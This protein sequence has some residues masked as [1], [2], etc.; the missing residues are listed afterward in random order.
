MYKTVSKPSF[1]L[2]GLIVGLFGVDFG[3]NHCVSL[4][5]F[6][7]ID[8]L[9]KTRKINQLPTKCGFERNPYHYTLKKYP[10]VEKSPNR[11]WIKAALPMVVD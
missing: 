10:S 3:K 5:T 7:A 2:I 1:V 9:I 8:L 6:I 11:G 4:G